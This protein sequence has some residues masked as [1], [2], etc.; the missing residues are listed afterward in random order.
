MYVIDT[1]AL[2]WYLTDDERLG[3]EAE[4]AME[5]IDN[6]EDAGV[7]PIIVILEAMAIFEKKGMKK[8]F[9]DVYRGIRDSSN[10][11]LYPLTSDISDEVLKLPDELELHDRVILATAKYLDSPLITKDRTLKKYCEKTIW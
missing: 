1:H 3:S 5:R 4:K 7:I 8:A 2:V 11:I 10:Y 9:L 6:M